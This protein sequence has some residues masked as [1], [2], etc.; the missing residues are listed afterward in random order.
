MGI[1]TGGSDDQF[2]VWTFGQELFE[3]SQQKINVERSFMGFIND[4]GVIRIEKS[5]SLRFCQQDAICHELNEGVARNLIGK[6]YFIAHDIAGV[7]AQFTSHLSRNGGGRDTARLSATDF[8]ED[9]S[10]G[11]KTHFWNLG[12]FA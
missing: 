9:T 3:V 1:N 4:E 6:P 8:P 11:F 5:V 12:S 2:Q 10:S 7:S